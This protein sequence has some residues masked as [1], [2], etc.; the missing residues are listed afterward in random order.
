MPA[1]IVTVQPTG[2]TFSALAWTA[3]AN[4]TPRV[5]PADAVAGEG[6]TPYEAARD[7]LA[8]AMPEEA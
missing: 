5:P 6:R 3:H 1:Y 7:A 8:A 2:P 4:S